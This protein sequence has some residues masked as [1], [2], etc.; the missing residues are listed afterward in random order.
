MKASPLFE[1]AFSS[2]KKAPEGFL[3]FVFISIILVLQY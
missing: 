2:F 1:L 3:I